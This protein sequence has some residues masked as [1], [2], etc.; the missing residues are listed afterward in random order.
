MSDERAKKDRR[1]TDENTSLN[2]EPGTWNPELGTR[3]LEPE[4]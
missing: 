4:T 1:R 2:P 3:N